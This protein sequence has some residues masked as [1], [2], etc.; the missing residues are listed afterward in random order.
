MPKLTF[1]VGGLTRGS[2]WSLD[3]QE[4]EVNLGSSSWTP[5]DAGLTAD[6]HDV[7]LSY[8]RD[9]LFRAQVRDRA[10]F[11]TKTLYARLA[12]EQEAEEAVPAP[13]SIEVAPQGTALEVSVVAPSTATQPAEQ[14]YDVEVRAGAEAPEDSVP[15]SPEGLVADPVR[16]PQGCCGVPVPVRPG[17]TTEHVHARLRRRSD[18]RAGPWLSVEPVLPP[19]D[20]YGELVDDDTAFAGAIEETEGFPHLEV[21]AGTLQFA[22]Y[23]LDDA[24]DAF[25]DLLFPRDDGGPRFTRGYYQTADKTHDQVVDWEPVICPQLDTL[26]R[27]A[28]LD[29]DRIHVPLPLAAEGQDPV[30]TTRLELPDDTSTH[31]EPPRL[32][33]EVSETQDG[34]AYGGFTPYVPGRVRTSK[35]YRSRVHL[36]SRLPLQIPVPSILLRRRRRNRK[37][38]FSFDLDVVTGD[39][40]YTFSPAPKVMSAASLRAAVQVVHSLT[41]AKVSYEIRVVSLSATQIRVLVAQVVRDQVTTSGGTVLWTFPQAFGATPR[42]TS[43]PIDP[44]AETFSGHHTPGTGTTTI[45]TTD[46]TGAA[47]DHP[48]DCHAIGPPPTGVVSVHVVLTGY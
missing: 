45:Y 36:V 6:S 28:I 32:E 13:T 48:V 34:S 30:D 7:E 40:T 20:D 11:L 12:V 10:G 18:G 4:R 8:R 29:D 31:E 16:A 2:S 9:V 21:D 14:V 39:K 43:S 1:R 26:A 23:P 15:Y 44:L 33:V 37:W 17:A 35:G 41:D 25:D 46:H 38:E 3:Y 27:D 5:V 22:P 24:T 19:L 42:I 47:V